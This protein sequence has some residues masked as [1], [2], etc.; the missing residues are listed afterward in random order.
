MDMKENEDRMGRTLDALEHPERFT[1][2]ELEE[3]LADRECVAA[4][5]DLLDCREALA[6]SNI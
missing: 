1:R 5:R 6:R 4:C 3:L 2:E